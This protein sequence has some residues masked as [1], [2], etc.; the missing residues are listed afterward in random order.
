MGD[1]VWS[2][3]KGGKTGQRIR[4][5][6]THVN[7]DSRGGT[8]HLLWTHSTRRP[9]K[10][11]KSVGNVKKDSENA[12][13]KILGLGASSTTVHRQE[14]QEDAKAQETTPLWEVA[15][16]GPNKKGEKG[17]PN[18]GGTVSMRISGNPGIISAINFKEYSPSMKF[19]QS[20]GDFP[21][22][23]RTPDG[24][25]S[26]STSES[27]LGTDSST[28]GEADNSEQTN[29]KETARAGGILSDGAGNVSLEE[30]AADGSRHEGESSHRGVHQADLTP[31]SGPED[32]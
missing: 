32:C 13:L 15:T 6:V 18:E 25:A 28:D 23:G 27:S 21:D 24:E 17:L 26:T 5:V 14:H 1:I 7:L 19:H 4:N 20:V 12:Q 31:A 2:E 9:E 3:L 11:V 10:A 22:D 29:N 16:P 30:T 8:V